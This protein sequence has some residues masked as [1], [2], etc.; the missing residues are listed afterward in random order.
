M[1]TSG[2]AHAWTVL[3][4]KIV[5][6]AWTNN[7]VLCA[8]EQ[9]NLTLPAVPA[10]AKGILARTSLQVATLWYRVDS[11]KPGRRDTRI[12]LLN[13]DG[14]ELAVSLQKVDLTTAPRQRCVASFPRLPVSREGV[15]AVVTEVKDNDGWNEVS[16]V[17][18]DVKVNW[19][20]GVALTGAVLGSPTSPGAGRLAD[21]AGTTEKKSRGKG[22]RQRLG[23]PKS[24][25]RT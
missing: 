19:V 18:L 16:R 15:F 20:T 13:P 5:L 21:G 24:S 25:G 6:D 12:R 7:V 8:I 4:D 14:G 1:A 11:Q 2:V 9:V 10:G 17:P 3:A 22:A 23:A